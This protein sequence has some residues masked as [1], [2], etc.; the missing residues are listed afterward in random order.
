MAKGH[1]S[2]KLAGNVPFAAAAAQA[3]IRLKGMT[4]LYGISKRFLTYG[5]IP[6]HMF[7]GIIQNIGTVQRASMDQGLMRCA[8][9]LDDQGRKGLQKGASI[10]VDGVCLTVVD[11]DHAQVWFDIIGETLQ[12]TTLKSLKAGQR[13]NIERAARFGDEIGGHLL[14]GHIY[15]TASI[16]SMTKTGLNC[17]VNFRCPKEWMKYLFPKGYIAINGASLTLVDVDP[18]GVFSVHLIPETLRQTTFDS[19]KSGDLVNLEIDSQ[20]QAI[21]D[22]AERWLAHAHELKR[23]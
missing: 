9:A 19:K 3:R 18:E 17:V 13:V 15:G 16:E 5:W 14:S 6:K 1:I 12:R 7:T 11:F 21:V 8:I 22:T 20:T 10:S 2:L 4:A 23:N